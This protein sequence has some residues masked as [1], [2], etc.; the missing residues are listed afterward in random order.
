MLTQIDMQDVEMP[1]QPDYS[2]N[3]YMLA[4]L[5]MQDV[6]MSTQPDYS[7]NLY[8]LTQLDMQDV[9]MPTQPYCSHPTTATN[10]NWEAD[11]ERP[12]HI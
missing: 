2:Q 9:E 12:G 4:Q 11:R 3:L 1:T 6:E 5:D 10:T 7:Q 8:M